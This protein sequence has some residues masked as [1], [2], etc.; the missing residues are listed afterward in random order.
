MVSQAKTRANRL[1]RLRQLPLRA[2]PQEGAAD[3]CCIAP[4][5]NL[6]F[7][8]IALHPQRLYGLLETTKELR[9]STS[10]YIHLFPRPVGGTEL[11]V[12]RA[13]E[14]IRKSQ[15]LSTREKKKKKKKKQ[16]RIQANKA[17]KQ[18]NKQTNKPKQKEWLPCFLHKPRR[19]SSGAKDG[20]FRL[21]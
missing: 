18:T 9:P 2:V 6:S 7:F 8:S 20:L 15:L 16:T 21:I 14:L 5:V 1:H 17:N 12:T 10:S 11:S 3:A 19:Y 13:L 4:A